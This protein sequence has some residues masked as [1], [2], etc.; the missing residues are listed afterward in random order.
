MMTIRD[1]TGLM[2]GGI[3]YQDPRTPSATWYDTHTWLEG[4]VAEVIAFRRANPGVYPEPEWTH[5]DFVRAQVV[6]F[7]CRRIGYNPEFC[8]D[9]SPA[10]AAPEVAASA[11]LCPTCGTVMVPV[12]CKTCGGAKITAYDCTNCKKSDE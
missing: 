6:E 3:A 12:F 5:P 8:I 4:R 11:K 2:P 1:R 10:M 7:N 9:D